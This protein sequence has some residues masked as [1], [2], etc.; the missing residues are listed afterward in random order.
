MEPDYLSIGIIYPGNPI[1]IHHTITILV[2][3]KSYTLIIILIGTKIY[4]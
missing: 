1:E 2:M 4:Q 3:I